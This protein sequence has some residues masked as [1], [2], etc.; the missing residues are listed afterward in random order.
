LIEG[1]REETDV[2]RRADEEQIGPLAEFD[3]LRSE[4]LQL[5]DQQWRTTT[6]LITT[7]GAVFGFGLSGNGRIP[8]LLIMPFA[9]YMLCSQWVH[10][11][12]LINRAAHYIRTELDSKVSGGLGYEQWLKERRGDLRLRKV[13][14]NTWI[15]PMVLIY[16]AMS[17]L[18]LAAVAIWF[19]G[20]R[21]PWINLVVAV[22]A[23]AWLFGLGLTVLSLILMM[24]SNRRIAKG[25]FFVSFFHG[26]P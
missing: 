26:T 6:V 3:A 18:A 2:R 7:T 19:S 23:L 14:A 13:L 16:P 4:I 12:D 8:L 10:S 22:G 11:H 20:A 17:S 24:R 1:R 5:S 21:L 25:D 9:A 15:Q